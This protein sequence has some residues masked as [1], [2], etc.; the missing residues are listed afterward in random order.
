[1]PEWLNG[2]VSKIVVGATPPRVRIPAS[3]P[4]ISYQCGKQ[5]GLA[6]LGKSAGTE[7]I[8]VGQLQ[9]RAETGGI[10]NSVRSVLLKYVPLIQIL[11]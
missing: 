7:K 6:S 11:V 9:S 5:D 10:L 4:P 1:V 3:P 8:I 2:T